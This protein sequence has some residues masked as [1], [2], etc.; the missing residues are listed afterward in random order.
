MQITKQTNASIVESPRI[1]NIIKK[2]DFKDSIIQ[3]DGRS[4]EGRY[5]LLPK[6]SQKNITK[7]FDI[8]GA[9]MVCNTNN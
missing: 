4:S 1:E 8:K 7:N 9:T 3:N 2:I 6:S 5:C